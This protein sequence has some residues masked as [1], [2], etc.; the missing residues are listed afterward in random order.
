[1][2]DDTPPPKPKG[3]R[4]DD[5]KGRWWLLSWRPATPD[6]PGGY[7]FRAEDGLDEVFF[8]SETEQD[9]RAIERRSLGDARQLLWKAR[10]GVL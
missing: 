6:A 3:R 7:L 10:S 2:I 8:P 1:M 5:K 9:A 4:F